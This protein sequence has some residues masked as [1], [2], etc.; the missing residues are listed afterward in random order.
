ML[1]FAMTREDVLARLKD[2]PL[3]KEQVWDFEN[4]QIYPFFR[5]K[6]NPV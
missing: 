5:P 6:R 3:V 2:D 1:V 4:A